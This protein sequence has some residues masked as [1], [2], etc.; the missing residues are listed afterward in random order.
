MSNGKAPITI[1]IPMSRLKC[2][3]PA[4]VAAGLVI[5]TWAFDIEL[6]FGL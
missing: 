6:L 1:E 5:W 3:M 2:Q 4:L